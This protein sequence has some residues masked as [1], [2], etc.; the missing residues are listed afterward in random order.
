MGEKIQHIFSWRQV[1]AEIVP[2]GG[3]DLGDAALHQGFAGRDELHHGR[4]LG[5]QVRFHGGDQRRALHAGQQMAE[6]AL[7]GAL[8]CAE[9]G[10]LGIAV[11]GAV[12]LH[13]AGGLQRLLDVG[14]DDLE[15]TGIGVVD[16]AL[17]VR[18]RVLQDVDVHPVVGERAGLVEAEGLEVAGN[19][20]HRRDTAGLHGRDERRAFL[21]RGLAG[22]PEAETPCVGEAGHGGG[23]GGGDVEDAGV[24]QCVL[25]AQARPS[26]LRGPGVAARALGPGGVG[27]GVRL[28]EDDDA[29]EGVAVVLVLAAGEPGDDLVEAR[30]LPL[31]GRRAQRGIGGEE[32]ALRLGNV[33]PLADLGQRDHILLAPADGG[34]VAA[35]VLEQL[36]G[37][38]DQSARFRPRSSWSRTMAATCLPLPQPVPS[39]SIQPRRKRTGADSGSL[40]P[41]LS[42]SSSGRAWTARPSS[43]ASSLSR[44][45]RW[46]VS[47]P[48][49]MR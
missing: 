3:R 9:R 41:A 26:L 40:S 5:F 45:T 30:L 21:E 38:A 7:L 35:R 31:P 22:G 1:D 6:E 48:A 49:P 14:M 15:R 46:T 20:F 13:D 8:E 25:Q 23:A 43:S 19:H 10:G 39:P 42:S 32:D 17:F 27:H 34:P 11:E 44:S 18:E 37:L 12:P 4:P 16:A 29:R 24:G 28:V 47:H 2:F 33:G 36:V